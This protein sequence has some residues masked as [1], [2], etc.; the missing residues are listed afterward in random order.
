MATIVR[1][2]SDNTITYFAQSAD[3][4]AGYLIFIGTD[5]VRTHVMDTTADTHE[6]INDV[7]LPKKYYADCITY[8]DGTYTILTDVVDTLNEKY[9]EVG[10]QTIEV[11]I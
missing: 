9:A 11:E 3:F 1:R 7:T 10:A 8:I 6:I 2:K 4:D 5:G